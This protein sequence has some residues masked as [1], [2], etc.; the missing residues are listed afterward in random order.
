MNQL[1]AS[2]SH[3]RTDPPEFNVVCRTKTNLPNQTES[4]AAL[5]PYLAHQ[6]SNSAH[7]WSGI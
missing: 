5:L 7:E 3:S 2:T 6:L 4:N 1:T